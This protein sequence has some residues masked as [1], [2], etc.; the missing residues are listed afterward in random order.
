MK[1]LL[2]EEAAE[3][4]R[5]SK[6]KLLEQARNGLIPGAKIGG[7]WRF[8][9]EDIEAHVRKLVSG[10]V[11]PDEPEVEPVRKPVRRQPRPPPV[12]KSVGV[13]NW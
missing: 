8:V 1:I 13:S 5:I 11:E 4:L 3:L 6:Y 7:D 9:R 10:K 12:I 2:P